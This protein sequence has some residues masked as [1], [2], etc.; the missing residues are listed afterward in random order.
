MIRGIADTEWTIDTD[1]AYEDAD[2]GFCLGGAWPDYPNFEDMNEN[3]E[4]N[5]IVFLHRAISGE[6]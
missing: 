6:I 2:F 1:D 5:L 4:F 3:F